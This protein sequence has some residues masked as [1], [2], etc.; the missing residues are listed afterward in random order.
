MIFFTVCSHLPKRKLPKCHIYIKSQRRNNKRQRDFTDSS[1]LLSKYWSRLLSS[2][3][4]RENNIYTSGE[5]SGCRRQRRYSQVKKKQ[6]T[7]DISSSLEHKD[8]CWQKNLECTY[9]CTALLCEDLSVSVL[10]ITY[11]VFEEERATVEK[12]A[13]KL[14]SYQKGVCS[15]VSYLY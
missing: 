11:F 9:F 4:I 13:E 2:V 8:I 1:L 12:E 7:W 10:I 5:R 6:N 3:E 15:C 14:T